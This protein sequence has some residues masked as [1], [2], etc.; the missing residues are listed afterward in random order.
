MRLFISI[1]IFITYFQGSFCQIKIDTELSLKL[2]GK[3]KFQDIKT[4]V[5]SH[6]NEKLAALDIR[7][8]VG[9]K[10]IMRQMKKWNREFWINEY[11]TDEEG[12]VKPQSKVIMGA[13]GIREREERRSGIRAQAENWISNGPIS[14]NFSTLHGEGVGRIDR[15]AFHPNLA[16]TI[17]AGS[18]FGGLFKTTDGGANWHPISSFVAS[19]GVSGIAVNY[20]NPNIIYVLSGDGDSNGG[21]FDGGYC[22]PF[23]ELRSASNGVYKTVNGG[24]SWTKLPDFPD[25]TNSTIYQGR[26]LII[27]PTDPTILFAATSRGLYK[28]I[29]S[30]AN[31]TKVTIG[32]ENIWDVKFKPGNPQT[33]YCVGND[34]IKRSTNYG[35]NFIQLAVDGLNLATR[36]SIA[37]TP[38]NPNKIALLAGRSDIQSSLVGVF[39]SNNSGDVFEQTYSDNNDN[40]FYN[41]IDLNNVMNQVNYDNVIAISPVD[42]N[43]ILA[44]GLCLWRSEDGGY[45]WSQETAYWP[46]SDFLHEYIHPDQHFLAYAPNGALYVANDGGVY[47]SYLDN[48]DDWDFIETGLSATQFYHF[49]WEND[50]GDPW[51]GAQDNGILQRINYYEYTT[52]WGGDGYDVM[53]DHPWR[54]ANGNSD[55]IYY[56][57]N[58]IIR[59]DDTDISVPQNVCDICPKNFFGNL[60]MDPMDENIIYVGYQI[61]LYRSTNAGDDWTSIGTQPSNWSISTCPSDPDIIYVAGATSSNNG[62]IQKYNAPNWEPIN[63]PP[64]PYTGSLK[65]TDIEV[66]PLISDLVHIS[67]GGVVPNAKVFTTTTGG[68]SWENISFNLPNVPVFCIK[69]D[70]FN[71]LYVGTS[72]GVYY[73]REGISH[74][75]PYYNGLPPVPV[76]QIEIEGNFVHIST[77]GRGLWTTLKYNTDCVE[78]RN[79]TGPVTGRNYWEASNIITSTQII[80]DS[81]GTHIT[82]N[83]GNKVVLSPGLHAKLGTT[84]K[85]FATG[86]GGQ[87]DL[88][89]TANPKKKNKKQRASKASEDLKK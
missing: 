35:N 69:K 68:S 79:M 52:Y 63:N 65:I 16:N 80:E 17:W 50:E 9:R 83:A 14:T 40:L 7:D 48:G 33:M 29:D 31:W 4:T 73:K 42:D 82:Y 53:T 71:G 60:A 32:N 58:E 87:V 27:H 20:N 30:G 88:S 21:C 12:N 15:L 61:G 43:I 67:V 57:V 76:T 24:E 34:N 78:D 54:A 84:L 11:Y 10:A 2:E 62:L 86:C 89:K 38:A 64:S 26:N 56:T 37:V 72:I 49:E 22:L 1:L 70:E 6:L 19:L 81:P 3:T 41:Y 75:E 51:G 55:D 44:G 59:S 47:V 85:V 77:F 25:V 13:L 18:P 66:D 5:W 8:S 28:T 74:W 23:G 45:N 36:I 39:I 46:T